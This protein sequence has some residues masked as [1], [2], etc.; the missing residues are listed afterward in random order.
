MSTITLDKLARKI[1]EDPNELDCWSAAH[2]DRKFR[3]TKR[4]S[5]YEDAL[6]RKVEVIR[7]L[8]SEGVDIHAIDQFGETPLHYAAGHRNTY[9]AEV[10]ISNGADVNTKNNNGETPLHSATFWGYQNM[11]ELLMASGADITAK[12]SKGQTAVDIAT[13]QDYPGLGILLR[14]FEQKQ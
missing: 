13:Q 4:D 11:V 12:N 8:I 2:N 14:G 10:L 7:V 3:T 1:T 6:E 5:Q 9:V